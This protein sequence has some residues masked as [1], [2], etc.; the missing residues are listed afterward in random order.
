VIQVLRRER[1]KAA[2][3]DWNAIVIRPI[4]RTKGLFSDGGQAEI[5]LSD[6]EHRIMLQM[7][8]KLSIGSINLHLKS[9]QLPID[10]RQSSRP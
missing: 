5:W 2:G 1:I 4:I 7:K 6:D 8:S 9:H 3:R 10:R